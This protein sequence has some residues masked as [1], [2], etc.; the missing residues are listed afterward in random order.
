MSFVS[1]RW[2]VVGGWLSFADTVVGKTTDH[3]PPITDHRRLSKSSCR[4]VAPKAKPAW[5]LLLTATRV[6]FADPSAV[7]S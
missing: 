5:S 2:P 4:A 1:D 6:R 7:A 3:R